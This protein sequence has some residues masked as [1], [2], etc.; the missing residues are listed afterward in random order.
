MNTYENT[1]K[2][3]KE[4]KKLTRVE[5][6]TYVKY[7]HYKPKLEEIL[8]NCLHEQKINNNYKLTILIDSVKEKLSH[9]TL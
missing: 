4:F 7:T 8:N 1:E 5:Y 9:F 6:K 3:E 2:L